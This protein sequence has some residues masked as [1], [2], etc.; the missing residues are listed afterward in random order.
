MKKLRKISMLLLLLLTAG[1]LLCGFDSEEQKVYDDADL[2][3]EEELACL[4]LS[5]KV[6]TCELAMRFLTDYLD[7]DLYFKVNSPD[8]NL[9]RAHAQMRLLEDML[10]MTLTMSAGVAELAIGFSMAVGVIFGL[11]PAD[12]A[13]KLK[14]ID[15]LHYD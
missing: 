2:L 13:S 3:T 10:G 11:Y 14:P 15:A 7:G 6:M 1:T 9:I 4:P 5:I 12:K 8:H